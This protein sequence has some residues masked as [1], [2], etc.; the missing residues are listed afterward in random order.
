M[1]K[2]LRVLEPVQ[3]LWGV[4]LLF[5]DRYIGNIVTDLAFVLQVDNINQWSIISPCTGDGTAEWKRAG[6]SPKTACSGLNRSTSSQSMTT[7]LLSVI[8]T[9]PFLPEY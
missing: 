7:L 1:Y 6:I 4:N 2:L 5:L 8:S 9:G 3:L